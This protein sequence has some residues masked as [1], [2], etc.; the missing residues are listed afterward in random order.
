MKGKDSVS[1]SVLCGFI[2]FQKPSAFLSREYAFSGFLDREGMNQL[3]GVRSGEGS[4]VSD[5]FFNFSSL[6]VLPSRGTCA[7][8]S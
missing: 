7:A 8:S 3:P 1:T 2:L 4:P 6:E 5:H